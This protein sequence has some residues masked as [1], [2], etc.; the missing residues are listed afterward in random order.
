LI[1]KKQNFGGKGGVTQFYFMKEVN[2]DWFT[3]GEKVK[4]D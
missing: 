1:I 4:N 2:R 3:L